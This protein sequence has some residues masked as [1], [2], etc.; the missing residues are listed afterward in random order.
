MQ[1]LASS[2]P[3]RWHHPVLLACTQAAGEGRAGPL[4]PVQPPLAAAQGCLCLAGCGCLNE[5]LAGCNHGRQHPLIPTI[6]LGMQGSQLLPSPL[7]LLRHAAAGTV[8]LTTRGAEAALELRPPGEE[9]MVTCR[10]GSQ[11]LGKPGLHLLQKGGRGD[12]TQ[13][14]TA[15][16]A[17]RARGLQ[18]HQGEGDGAVVTEGA[19]AHRAHSHPREEKGRN[20]E[21]IQARGS[22]RMNI[23]E[24]TAA[25]VAHA[26]DIKHARQR[27]LPALLGAHIRVGRPS[28]VAQAV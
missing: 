16:A 20:V 26:P 28:S 18:A 3:Q 22:L 14:G 5:S 4:P 2:A 25:R 8:Q 27:L 19:A 7:S 21:A 17:A 24:C 23:R 11:L 10:G 1:Q 9:G 13:P 15:K 12:K 6:H